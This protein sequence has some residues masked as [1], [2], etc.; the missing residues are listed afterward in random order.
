MDIGIHKRRIAHR[1]VR[2][3]HRPGAAEF[4]LRPPG[5]NERSPHP[6]P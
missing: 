2:R 1:E 4:I 6:M 5:F 3:P